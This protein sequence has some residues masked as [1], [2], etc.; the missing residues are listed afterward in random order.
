MYLYP[1]ARQLETGPEIVQAVRR[2]LNRCEIIEPPTPFARLL[3][4]RRLVTEETLELTAPGLFGRAKRKLTAIAT[5]AFKKIRGILD[6]K[7][8]LVWVD[9]DLHRHRRVFVKLHELGHDV[10]KW[11]HDLFVITSENDLRPDIRKVFESEANRFAAECT[12][13]VD[14]MA[15]A[16][17]G[18]QL[19]IGDLC[20]LASQYNASLTA[21]ARHYVSI[22][23]LPVA[24]LLGKVEIDSHGSPAIRFSYGF[25]NDAYA[26]QFGRH[27]SVIGFPSDHP[28]CAAVTSASPVVVPLTMCDMRGD[29][30]SLTAGTLY[31]TYETL[32]LIHIAAT[33]TRRLGR[34]FRGWRN[35]AA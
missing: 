6:V 8:R 19:D 33:P 5:A 15:K 3:E 29:D 30:R 13:Q 12:F 9:P 32:T 21:T 27:F 4:S 25:A 18:R 26:R 1:A 35:A 16:H 22:Q 2:L 28:A 23:D 31:N 14:D 7:G 24:L 11:H 10:I 20:A 17:R 34:L